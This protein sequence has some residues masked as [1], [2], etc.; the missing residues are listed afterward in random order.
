MAG[1]PVTKLAGLQ[2]VSLVD[3]DVHSIACFIIF[4]DVLN[5]CIYFHHHSHSLIFIFE[6]NIVKVADI[7][8]FPQ[9]MVQSPA[10]LSTARPASVARRSI[11]YIREPSV[12]GAGPATGQMPFICQFCSGLHVLGTLRGGRLHS[13]FCLVTSCPSP[14]AISVNVRT[15]LLRPASSAALPSDCLLAPYA[16]SIP[17]L[18]PLAVS[19]PLIANQDRSAASAAVLPALSFSTPPARP[20]SQRPPL[21]SHKPVQEPSRLQNNVVCTGV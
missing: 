12:N 16:S 2:R 9:K 19:Q 7:N 14:A 1:S 15:D 11:W 17:C 4:M 8:G 20:V 13:F 5:Y 3:V 18:L 21:L 6:F 10:N